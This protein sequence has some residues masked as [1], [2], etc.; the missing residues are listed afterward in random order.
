[1]RKPVVFKDRQKSGTF[2]YAKFWNGERYTN[3]TPLHIPVEGKKERRREAEQA[4]EALAAEI[5]SQKPQPAGAEIPFMDYIE[6]FWSDD[7]KYVRE[8]KSVEQNP[9][10]ASY[11]TN[12]HNA[13]KNHMRDF[14]GF[15]GVTL[16]GLTKPLI[17]DWKLWMAENGRSGKTINAAVQAVR[18]PVRV[19]LEDEII[20]ADPFGNVK[21][22]FHKERL[23]GI[24]RPAEIKRLIEGK[25]IDPYHRLAVY[26]A[27]YCSMR[28]GEARGL[29]WGDIENGII[30]IHHNYQDKEGVKGC[31][32][33]SDGYV[34]LPGVVADVLNQVHGLSP[35]TGP[36]D[37]VLSRRPYHPARK[38]LFL[39]ALRSELFMIGIT[40]KQ[41][42]ER[43][44]V[45]HSL[46]HSFV[47][48][49]R[50]AGIRD[51]QIMLM[52]RHKDPKMLARYSDHP[53]ALN[54]DDM[55]KQIDDGFGK[56]MEGAG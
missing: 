16:G 9:L 39:E 44:I 52:S 32:D 40:E 49:C 36:G 34:P 26:L 20:D 7:S 54:M 19:A 25:V 45:Y 29:Q 35:L 6:H 3:A 14:P 27:L 38:K 12:S 15:E 50:M 51:F 43:N 24:L 22:A 30:H 46:R 41:R 18:V 10:A 42:V 48:A 17:K 21:K 2:W 37:F 1:M 13:V 23:R 5:S 56:K 11:V 53:D 47:T 31:K 28:M 8:K 33:G 55:R 4:A